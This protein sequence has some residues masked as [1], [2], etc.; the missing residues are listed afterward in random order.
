MDTDLRT[1]RTDH[2]V[3]ADLKERAV[4]ALAPLGE[5]MREAAG[6]GMQLQFGV[7]FD[8]FGRPQSQVKVIKEL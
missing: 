6:H 4:A 2:E 8:Q 1:V 3:A 5:L 7:A